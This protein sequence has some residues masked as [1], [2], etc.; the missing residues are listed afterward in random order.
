MSISMKL[1]ITCIH[2]LSAA[3][4]GAI[5][6]HEANS[7]LVAPNLLTMAPLILTCAMGIAVF[8]HWRHL[9]K[10]AGIQP[11]SLARS[12]PES[13]AKLF[14]VIY[15]YI[16][17]AIPMRPSL[18]YLTSIDFGRENSFNP[19]SNCSPADL[20]QPVLQDRKFFGG[21]LLM[22][23]AGGF[24]LLAKGPPSFAVALKSIPL[25]YVV[26]Q[27]GIAV[28]VATSFALILLRAHFSFS[29]ESE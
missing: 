3:M 5:Y 1:N 17:Y 10:S 14:G 24:S 11:A 22:F 23:F 8:V 6:L 21:L 19:E 9:L 27:W 2:I 26:I 13:T 16:P 15:R 25:A 4:L 7:S 18:T 29:K 20:L 28:L 12:A